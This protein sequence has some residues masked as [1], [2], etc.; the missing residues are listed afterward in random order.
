MAA[1]ADSL[2]TLSKSARLNHESW[3]VRMV[4]ALILSALIVPPILLIVSAKVTLT[5]LYWAG[6]WVYTTAHALG[7][8]AL[9]FFL[10]V[11]ACFVSNWKD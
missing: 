7:S 11:A 1:F 10:L 5:A 2:K 9:L 3:A 8:V 4:W 6:H